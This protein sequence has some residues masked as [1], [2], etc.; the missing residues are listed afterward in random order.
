[1]RSLYMTKPEP[2]QHPPLLRP[3]ADAL[4]LDLD[5]T[6]LDI[7]E[8]P[9]DVRASAE[10]LAL[11][12]RLTSPMG[13]AVALITG[14]S[15]G[16][17]DAILK[18]AVGAVAG[19]HGA[20]MRYTVASTVQWNSDNAPV[21]A[22]RAD[23]YALAGRLKLLVEDKRGSLALHYRHAPEVASE[24]LAGAEQI[25]AR[26]GLRVMQGQMVV[27]LIAG[28]RTKGDA[29][30]AFMNIA[31]FAGRRPVAVGDDVTDEDAFQS[32]HACCGFGVLVGQPRTTAATFG[33]DGPASVAAWL[34]ASV[35]GPA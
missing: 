21:W 9:D 12:S 13:G 34:E 14:R 25:A 27:E 35:S 18:G 29:L 22:A 10:L 32:A 24:T 20:E 30:S 3:N 2:L 28:M 11:L 15:V 26:Y 4:F 7:A 33:L 16:D 6:L 5:G 8:H 19:V 23:A 1:M 31:P 17:A